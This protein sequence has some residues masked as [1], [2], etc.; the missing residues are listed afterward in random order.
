LEVDTPATVDGI[1]VLGFDPCTSVEG[2]GEVR[3]TGTGPGAI[4]R[5]IQ[6]LYGGDGTSPVKASYDHQLGQ[7]LNRDEQLEEKCQAKET[8]NLQDA[9]IELPR[10]FFAKKKK[11][12]HERVRNFAAYIL[13]ND[14]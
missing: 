4:T 13:R 9:S 8:C 14:G 2:D 3:G 7:F 12:I 6:D 1:S 10:N 11:P 5:E